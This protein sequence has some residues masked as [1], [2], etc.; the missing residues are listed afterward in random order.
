LWCG[1]GNAVAR[2]AYAVGPSFK[3]ATFFST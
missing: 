1:G 2:I 3:A